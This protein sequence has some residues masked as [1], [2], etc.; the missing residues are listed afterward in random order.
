[1]L[2][3][4]NNNNVCRRQ[5]S[6]LFAWVTV[7]RQL[8]SWKNL[9][10]LTKPK[11]RV[12]P[13]YLADDFDCCLDVCVPAKHGRA[14]AA[15][16]C[17]RQ[18]PLPPHCGRSAPTP[19]GPGCPQWRSLGTSTWLNLDGI[20]VRW[21]DDHP[22]PP[23]LLLLFRHLFH[24]DLPLLQVFSCKGSAIASIGYSSYSP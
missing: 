10:K 18:G 24:H 3:Q 15:P 4:T 6:C 13:P 9:T 23:S 7:F 22:R 17:L 14:P 8:R 16:G 11:C 5:R 12:A 20:D 2:P 21:I 19:C 1:M